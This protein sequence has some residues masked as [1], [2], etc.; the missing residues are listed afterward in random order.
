M[1]Q[2]GANQN[3]TSSAVQCRFGCGFYA[4]SAF[5]G[6]CSKCYNE[7]L[8]QQKQGLQMVP[9]TSNG[10]NGQAPFSSDMA[11]GNPVPSEAAVGPSTS[12]V[13]GPSSSAPAVPRVQSSTDATQ[14]ASD[15]SSLQSL[16]SESATAGIL[17][18]GN[19]QDFVCDELFDYFLAGLF[20]GFTK[21]ILHFG[22]K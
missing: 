14:L 11:G 16:S 1:E 10:G 13:I 3:I 8:K 7:V 21:Q 4:S 12:T 20:D 2:D 5:D 6:L 18:S 15:S 22:P 19:G 9:T 17:T